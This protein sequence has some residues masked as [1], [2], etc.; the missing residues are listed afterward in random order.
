MI[1]YRGGESAGMAGFF[2]GY[3]SLECILVHC[4]VF[5]FFFTLS[6]CFYLVI[7]FLGG[8]RLRLIFFALL[9]ELFLLSFSL[10]P[11]CFLAVRL[12]LA[13]TIS[14]YLF[15][16]FFPFTFQML[17]LQL[18]CTSTFSFILFFEFHT[19]PFTGQRKYRP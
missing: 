3:W 13:H 6:Y 16:L 9:I 7:R 19:L 17:H 15:T 2:T 14:F 18:L 11:T 5:C 10:F 12:T 8:G 1:D 4:A